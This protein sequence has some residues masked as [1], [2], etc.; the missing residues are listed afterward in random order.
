MQLG[1]LLGKLGVEAVALKG[2][3][4]RVGVT[5]Q[6]FIEFWDGSLASL[7]HAFS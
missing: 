5:P 3:A 2:R 1:A 7:A 4:L 6:G